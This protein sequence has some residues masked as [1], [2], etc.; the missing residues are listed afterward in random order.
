[1]HLHSW[2]KKGFEGRGCVRKCMA[3][4][5]VYMIVFPIYAVYTNDK[6]F[7]IHSLCV[8]VQYLSVLTNAFRFL[9]INELSEKRQRGQKMI[10]VYA[11]KLQDAP[12]S[13]RKKYFQWS[14]I[15]E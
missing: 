9:I 15:D 6:A 8:V 4:A 12:R 1:M 14:M 2:R 5:N 10:Y 13:F 11:C 3:A 7:S